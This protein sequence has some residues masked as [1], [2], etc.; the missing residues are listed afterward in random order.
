MLSERVV[1]RLFERLA[2]SYGT[3]WLALWDG[4]ELPA[5]RAMWAAELGAYAE[6][7]DALAWALER[8]PERAPNLP[9]F[10]ALVAQAP[11]PETPALPGPPPDPARVAQAVRSMRGPDSTHAA[12]GRTLAQ[13]CIDGLIQRAERDK[14]NR[15]QRDMLA[16]CLR[17]LRHGDPRLQHPVVL[18]YAP[19]TPVL[20]PAEGAPEEAAA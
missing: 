12:D 10:K 17:M 8:L 2:L 16:S 14:L 20:S 9:A 4:L 15:A 5:V 7:L 19:Q 18:R 6:R 11:R 3:Q 13:Q 1:E